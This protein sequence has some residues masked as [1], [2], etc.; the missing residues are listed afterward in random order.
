MWHAS[1]RSHVLAFWVQS[2][3]S[4]NPENGLMLAEGAL[5]QS[6][7]VSGAS[8][9]AVQSSFREAAKPLAR[10]E[11]KLEGSKPSPLCT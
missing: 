5:T 10:I 8:G 3:Q 9:G 1:Y 4:A 2:R 11:G 7:Y 6:P